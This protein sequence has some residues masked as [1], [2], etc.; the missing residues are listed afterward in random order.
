MARING[1]DGTIYS[2][3][4]TGKDGTTWAPFQDPAQIAVV[5]RAL[6]IL[7][8][9]VAP[10]ASIND[11]FRGLPNHRSFQEVVEDP[12]IWISRDPA[13]PAAAET[14]GMHITVGREPLRW[15]YW[16]VAATLLHE[17]AHINGATDIGG[18]AE[19]ALNHGGLKQHFVRT[20]AVARPRR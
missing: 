12:R 6:S 20:N 14:V 3:P 7:R 1:P 9:Q 19:E 4:D 15:G 10:M 13:G 8:L 18:Q 16:A 2:Q 11:Y 17:L 5:R